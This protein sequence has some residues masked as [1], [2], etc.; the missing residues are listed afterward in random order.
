MDRSNIKGKFIVFEGLDGCGKT[1]QAKM[2]TDL[3]AERG[4]EYI[5][6]REPGGTKVGD[7]LRQLLLDPETELTLWGEVLLLVAARAQLIQDV[8]RP[9]LAKGQAVVCD[10][11]LFSSF[12]YQGYGLDLDVELVKRINLEAVGGLLPDWTFFLD[13]DFQTGLARQ[14]NRRDLDRIE[15]RDA[16]FFKRVVEGYKQLAADY[17]FKILPGTAPADIIH[18]QVA[19]LLKLV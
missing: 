15:K 5:H 1:T 18:R 12:A 3:F 9:A 19:A 11:Y 6:V 4:I 10:R 16:G 17:G 14:A 8:V 13:V 7:Q 2:L